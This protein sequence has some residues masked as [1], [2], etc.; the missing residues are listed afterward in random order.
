MKISLFQIQIHSDPL[1]LAK[2]SRDKIKIK[3]NLKRYNSSLLN[4]PK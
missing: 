4:T 1:H 2:E 3:S